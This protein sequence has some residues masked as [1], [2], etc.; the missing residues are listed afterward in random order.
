M[1]ALCL[2]GSISPVFIFQIT[3]V[4]LGFIQKK[5]S[6][7]KVKKGWSGVTV[8][9]SL[10]LNVLRKYMTPDVRV[11]SHTNYEKVFDSDLRIPLFFS[12]KCHIFLMRPLE[13]EISLHSLHSTIF[14]DIYSLE[15][16]HGGLKTCFHKG[17]K[18]FRESLPAFV[19]RATAKLNS[20]FI[21]LNDSSSAH[22]NAC[23]IDFTDLNDIIWNKLNCSQ[24][25]N[26]YWFKS[27]YAVMQSINC[28]TY[29]FCDQY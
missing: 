10:S 7:W 6:M 3:Y 14:K 28:L 25:D 22:F 12:S 18:R 27:W 17:A 8:S 23:R 24:N 21:D 5:T 1:Q 13:W 15:E 16:I 4:G 20:K 9:L 11:P 2:L 29:F 19:W 26:F